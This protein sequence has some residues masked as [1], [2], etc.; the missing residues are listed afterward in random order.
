MHF[1][2][3]KKGTAAVVHSKV[4]TQLTV[5]TVVKLLQHRLVDCNLPDNSPIKHSVKTETMWVP[6]LRLSVFR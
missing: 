4:N 3:S 1:R 6:Q 2:Q 5:A